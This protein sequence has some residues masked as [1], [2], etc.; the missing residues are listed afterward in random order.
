MYA[1]QGNDPN[2]A[3]LPP[4][5]LLWATLRLA[6]LRP[7]RGSF[8]TGP[9]ST[10]GRRNLS[11][12]KNS[13]FL[14]CAH[15]CTTKRCSADKSTQY[16]HAVLDIERRRFTEYKLI[17]KASYLK[18]L[19]FKNIFDINYFLRLFIQQKFIRECLVKIVSIQKA[20]FYTWN[21][22]VIFTFQSKHFIA[23]I[24]LILL[25][26]FFTGISS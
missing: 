7:H 23:K 19:N 8:L 2:P 3:S 17:Q 26:I 14:L 20:S 10:S 13:I 1:C 15:Q 9:Q 24:I 4:T 11:W 12:N 5:I 16:T 25:K 21:E 18:I 6:A 22:L